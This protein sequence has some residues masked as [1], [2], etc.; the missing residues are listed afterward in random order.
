MNLR[1]IQ[2]DR[3]QCQ[4]PR[5]LSE[6]EHLHEELFQFRQKGASKR[7]QRIVVGMQ[8]ACDEAKGHRLV[9]GTLHFP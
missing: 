4:Y 7:G 9:R 6:Q 5:L 2:A 8:I 3:A 1:S